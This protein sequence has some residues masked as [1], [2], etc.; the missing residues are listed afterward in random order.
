LSIPVK[1]VDAANIALIV[2][3]CGLAHV[4][5]YELLVFSYAVLGPAHYLT[6]ISWLHDRKYF[7]N[8]RL[9]APALLAFTFLLIVFYFKTSPLVFTALVLTAA[10]GMAFIFVLPDK[11]PLRLGATAL[12]AAVLA[13]EVY[14]GQ[15]ALFIAV[16]L[17]TVLHVFVFTASFMWVGATKSHK[18]T[19]YIAFY[20]LLIG[21][22][23]FLV[24]QGLSDTPDL[25]GVKFFQPVSLYM[26]SVM[27]FTPT[28]EKQIFG[29]LS[30][31][32][33]YHYLNWFSKAEVIHW[34]RIPR[35]RLLAIIAIY[36]LAFG[37][38][39]Y[40]YRI[41]FLIILFLAQAHVILEFPLNIR[42]FGTIA[43]SFRKPKP[44]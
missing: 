3:S 42:T 2:L 28:A 21:A 31:A 5:P 32:Y 34:N 40:S 19:A 12:V 38:Y 20:T 6:Q 16:L 4:F 24:P 36:I 8:S 35:A 11:A 10:F 1:Y 43:G 22:L 33:T 37:I 27:G 30:F 18:T 26:Q 13:L 29:F 44:A 23:T 39:L 15:M 14:I 9:I 41:G 25:D 7:V 17:P